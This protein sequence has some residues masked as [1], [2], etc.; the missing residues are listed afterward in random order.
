MTPSYLAWCLRLGMPIGSYHSLQI[1]V[2]V[3]ATTA[4]CL[5]FFFPFKNEGIS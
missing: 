4:H 2:R 5:V 1:W 3:T